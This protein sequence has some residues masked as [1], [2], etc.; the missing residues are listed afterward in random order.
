MDAHGI[1]VCHSL[2]CDAVFLYTAEY[3]GKYADILDEAI[4]LFR[5]NVLFRKFD[6]HG[7]RNSHRVVV[8]LSEF[9]LPTVLSFK[10]ITAGD[11]D[12]LLVYLTLFVNQ[13]LRRL[14]T[15]KS[16]GEGQKVCAHIMRSVHRRQ[17]ACLM[18]VHVSGLGVVPNGAF[19]H[20]W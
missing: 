7:E 2:R 13:C 5:A 19:C 10:N 9:P 11:G 16:K 14:E 8:D 20:S 4:A 1:L 3:P 18:H 6:I 15:V 17:L 12:R